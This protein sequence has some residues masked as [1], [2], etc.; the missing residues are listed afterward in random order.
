MEVVVQSTALVA[1]LLVSPMGSASWSPSVSS[2]AGAEQP[3]TISANAIAGATQLEC[4]DEV[5]RP[6]LQAMRHGEVPES[7]RDLRT[8]G[9][10][11]V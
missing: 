2:G 6:L 10:R 11:R 7:L 8:R 4:R 9:P 3:A 5:M 1:A